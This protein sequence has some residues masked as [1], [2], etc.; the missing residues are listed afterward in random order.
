M[1]NPTEALAA[2]ITEL[3]SLVATTTTVGNRHDLE[4]LL[5]RKQKKLDALQQHPVE[6]M[7]APVET[8]VTSGIA[9]DVAT[10]TEI[11]RFGWE[12]EGYGKDKVE[13]YIMSGID[14]V[15]ELPSEQVTCHFT[16]TSFDLKVS[17]WH[18]MEFVSGWR[19]RRW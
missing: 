12:D 19:E 8:A 16:K 2:E 5:H 11:S 14:G 3:Q 10:F 17:L 9:S 18:V 6:T 13:V 1:A 4:Q 7:T 15:G